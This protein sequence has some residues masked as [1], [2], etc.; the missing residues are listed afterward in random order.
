MRRVSA[1]LPHHINRL[2]ISL[3]EF[4]QLE[5]LIN[6]SRRVYIVQKPYGM[7]FMVG[8]LSSN[9]F[10][11]CFFN[12]AYGRQD[13]EQAQT[14]RDGKGERFLSIFC[15]TERKTQTSM[16]T[17]RGQGSA[18]FSL[19]AL[20][21][22]FEEKAI[23]SSSVRKLSTVVQYQEL[24]PALPIISTPVRQSTKTIWFEDSSINQY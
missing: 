9:I 19:N 16:S 3:N 12:D 23:K 2:H 1:F 10:K 7:W 18:Y 5:R 24:R 14:W 11:L 4:I 6:T 22:Y 15:G 21:L 20:R 13:T 8:F 17:R